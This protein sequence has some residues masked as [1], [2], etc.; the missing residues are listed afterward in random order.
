MVVTL[1]LSTYNSQNI[2]VR[3]FK[4]LLHKSTLICLLQTSPTT[5]Q[6]PLI[7]VKCKCSI[8]TTGPAPRPS[9]NTSLGKLKK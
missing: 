6:N 5:S 8:V 9:C 1:F 4:K 7:D 3:A 2:C